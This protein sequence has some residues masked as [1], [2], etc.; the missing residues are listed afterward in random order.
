MAQGTLYIINS[1][2][3]SVTDPKNIDELPTDQQSASWDGIVELEREIEGLRSELNSGIR[4]L[5]SDFTAE[6]RE[7]RAE[8]G[9]NLRH[10]SSTLHA[11]TR[12]HVAASLGSAGTVAAWCSSPPRSSERNREAAV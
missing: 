12:V 4:E 6:F 1:P 9:A 3:S 8:V 2:R 5:R 11:Q 10:L 7:F